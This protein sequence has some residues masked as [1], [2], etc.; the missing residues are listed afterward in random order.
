VE[1][2]KPKILI[3]GASGF[4]GMNLI[5]KLNSQRFDLVVLKRPSNIDYLKTLPKVSELDIENP[6]QLTNFLRTN[7]LYSVIHLA[8]IYNR[9]ESP[10]QKNDIWS[11]NFDLG[12]KLLDIA[13]SAH[14]QFIHIESY[15]QF[16]DVHQTEYLKSKV[17]FSEI[18]NLEREKGKIPIESLVFFDNYGRQDSRNKVLNALIASR[19]HGKGLR[20]LN[21]NAPI[22]LTSIEDVVSAILI[23]LNV[24]N[25][26]RFR[27]NGKDKFLIKEISDFVSGFPNSIPP[28]PIE[29]KLFKAEDID[30][31][32]H[33][34]QKMDLIQFL[35]SVLSHEP[36]NQS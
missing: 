13:V 1:I 3:S 32:K 5:R 4:T 34:V 12:R 26:G 25:S 30:P 16:E 33:F 23:S 21:P 2:V 6:Y 15:L 28:T 31:L 9:E 29:R 18:V 8:T 19:I 22:I 17:A 20:L 10:Q 27:V 11:A 7:E 35:K 24:K 14:A 36:G